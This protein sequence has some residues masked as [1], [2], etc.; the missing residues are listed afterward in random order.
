MGF[1]PE[2]PG[3]TQEV[4]SLQQQINRFAVQGSPFPVAKV[5]VDGHLAAGAAATAVRILLSRAKAAAATYGDS[6]ATSKLMAEAATALPDPVPFVAANLAHVTVTVALY[7]DTLGLPPPPPAPPS[8]ST[9][10]L[11][12][13]AAG[14][15]LLVASGKTRG[16]RWF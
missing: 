14:V 2:L 10:L 13:A 7:A 15:V 4:A 9:V 5:P 6:A 12:A 1:T 8:S 3:T 16:K 11:L